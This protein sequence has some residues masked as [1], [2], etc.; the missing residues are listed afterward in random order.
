MCALLPPS[1][2]F[3]LEA[4][5]GVCAAGF[6]NMCVAR[7]GRWLR[8]RKACW[9]M[10]FSKGSPLSAVAG[11][12]AWAPQLAIAHR[13]HLGSPSARRV[14]LRA[15][16]GPARVCD[17]G[18]RRFSWRQ[19]G[20]CGG[21]VW[22]A[23]RTM[24]VSAKH[25]CVAFAQV[26]GCTCLGH[27]RRLRRR[28]PSIRNCSAGVQTLRRGVFTSGFEPG[29]INV[30]EFDESGLIASSCPTGGD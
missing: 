29:A 7:V 6:S 1:S 19:C 12:A 5:R 22:I 20:R 21:R 9:W 23:S 11:G 14:R 17:W 25:A 3:S 13:C 26:I 15:A 18:S 8:R 24:D 2:M 28:C 4:G 10:L 30:T 27:L 16:W